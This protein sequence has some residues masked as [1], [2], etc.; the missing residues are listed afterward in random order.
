MQN[1]GYE[2][3]AHLEGWL[4]V[5]CRFLT[6]RK[7]GMLFLRIK[8]TDVKYIVP[9][10]LAHHTP[11][12]LIGCLIVLI[13]LCAVLSHSVVSD[14]LQPHGLHYSPPGSCVQGD[15]L[16]KNTGVGCHVFLRG[17]YPTQGLNPG[18]P[19]CRQ[20]LY[21]LSY[22]GSLCVCLYFIQLCHVGYKRNSNST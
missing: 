17:F 15:S 12:P 14:S 11:G 19:H 20:I 9:E 18:L 8:T 10:Y 22:Q 1:H 3:T 6:E 16:G 21:R 2:G 5:M 4:E 13:M 7:V